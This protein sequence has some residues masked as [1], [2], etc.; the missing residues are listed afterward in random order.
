V[1]PAPAHK[2]LPE[3]QPAE[4]KT[5]AAIAKTTR[6]TSRIRAAALAERPL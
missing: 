2:A 4:D 1:P 6:S 3:T 5:A